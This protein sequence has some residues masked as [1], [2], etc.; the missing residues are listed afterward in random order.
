MPSVNDFLVLLIIPALDYIVYPHLEKSM[1]F[2][3]R[4]L[5][6]VLLLA[7]LQ[8]FMYNKTIH[9]SRTQ[10][11]IVYVY[12]A[13]MHMFS[14]CPL[15]VVVGMIAAALSFLLSGLLQLYLVKLPQGREDCLGDVNI[16]W[17]LPQIVLISFAEVLV[18]V[19]GL[20]FAYSQAPP[21]FR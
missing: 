21:D 15:Q 19:T 2:K 18:S 4:P 1:G 7:S 10:Y 3:I 16:A 9:Y 14:P 6:K 13:C 17:Q 5:H 12:S 20:E 11:T 8:Y